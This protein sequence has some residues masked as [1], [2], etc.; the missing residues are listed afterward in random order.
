MHLQEAEAG[1]VAAVLQSL[2]WRLDK[3]VSAADRCQVLASFARHD[4]LMLRCASF[5][6]VLPGA[7]WIGTAWPVGAKS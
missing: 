1:L 7:H 4:I 5:A 3:A 6:L 2:R